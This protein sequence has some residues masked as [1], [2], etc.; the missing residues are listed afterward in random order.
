M[1]DKIIDLKMHQAKFP[2]ASFEKLT[3]QEQ[4]VIEGIALRMTM[5]M[6][7]ELDKIGYKPT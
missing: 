7:A 5:Q 1:T 3:K 4:S 2:D 6:A